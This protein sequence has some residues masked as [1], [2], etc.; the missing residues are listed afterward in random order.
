M[1][2]IVPTKLIKWK[3]EINPFEIAVA[4]FYYIGL[5]DIC[6]CFHCDIEIFLWK[7][8]D[9]PLKELLKFSFLTMKFDEQIP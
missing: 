8:Q 3:G 7:P 6:M 1:T 9:G 2:K 4:G 5:D